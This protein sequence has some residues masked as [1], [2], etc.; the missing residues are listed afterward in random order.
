MDCVLSSLTAD[1]SHPMQP[2]QVYFCPL[3]CADWTEQLPSG[4]SENYMLRR[5]LGLLTLQMPIPRLRIGPGILPGDARYMQL[6]DHTWGLE[7][8]CLKS[9]PRCSHRPTQDSSCP[10]LPT[11]AAAG[12]EQSTERISCDGSVGNRGS[13]VMWVLEETHHLPSPGCFC[14]LHST[15]RNWAIMI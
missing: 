13:A 4:S 12:E 11:T 6:P 9:Q 14:E 10:A 7:L 5:P 3:C 15:A 8:L 1:L 2:L